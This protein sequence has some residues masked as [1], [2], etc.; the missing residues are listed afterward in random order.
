MTSKLFEFPELGTHAIKPR[1]VRKAHP[2]DHFSSDFRYQFP[3]EDRD[4]PEVYVYTDQMSYDPGETVEFRVSTTADSWNIQIYR[5]GYRPE[6]AHEAFDLKGEFTNTSETAYMDGCDWPVLHSWRIPTDQRSGFYRIVSTC[7]RRD[8]QRFVQHHFVVV[9]P[10]EATRRGKIVFMPCTG[11]WTAYND[12]G[13]G[14]HY[15]GTWGPDKNHASP[16]LSLKRPWSRPMLWLPKGG[17]RTTVDRLPAMGDGPRYP[18]REWGY[19]QGFAQF[20]VSAGW[21]QYDRHFLVWAE[22]EGYEIDVITQTDLHYRPEL[23]EGYSCLAVAG[24]DEYWSWE[25]R[26]HVEGWVE[27]GGHFARF[28][29]NFLWQIRLEEEGARQ[30]CYKTLAPTHDPVRDDPERKHLLTSIWDGEAVNWH[31]SSTV[32][33]S[34]CHGM[35][36]G[37]GGHAP[38]GSRGFTVYRSDHW[39][40]EGTQLRYADVFGAEA[41]IFGYEVDGLEYTFRDGLPYPVDGSG[42]APEIDILAMTPA[43]MFEEEHPGEGRRFSLRDGDLHDIATLAGG[44]YATKR[45]KM[46]YGSGMLVAMARGAGEVVTAGSCEWVM[47]LTRR[48]EFTEQITRNVLSRFT[49]D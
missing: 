40:F 13:G 24:H 39:V 42:A 14:N 7:L 8:G 28:G 41:G 30:I 44:D 27:K 34:G 3:R 2:D 35:Y 48:D 18:A 33:V 38:R 43:T 31:G 32:G 11:T 37:F 21:A 23:L 19:Q 1:T 17:A 22:K 16:I 9:R 26:Q 12:W 49:A 45:R 5:D 36:S 25:M 47:G 46:Q 10:T 6:M 15:F 20:W 4:L 29:G